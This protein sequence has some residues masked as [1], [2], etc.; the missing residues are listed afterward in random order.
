M[1]KLLILTV[2]ILTLYGLFSFNVSKTENYNIIRTIDSVEIREY[3]SQIYASHYSEQTGNNSQFRVLAN[4]IFGGNSKNEQIGM[5]SP[6]NMRLSSENKEMLFL[7]PERYEMESLP[8]PNSNEIEII[9]MESRMVA[10]IRFSGYSNSAKVKRKKQELISTLEKYNI[11]HANEFELLVYDSPYKVLN[12][13][14]EVI[15]ILK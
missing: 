10:A 2:A 3:P 5:T 15:V 13:R 14:N 12:R 7:M 6:V 9:E 4:Y 1:K 8:A 11:T